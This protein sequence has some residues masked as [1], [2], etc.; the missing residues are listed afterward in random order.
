MAVRFGSEDAAV[1][2]RNRPSAYVVISDGSGNLV[3]VRSSGGHFLP[4]GG[5]SAGENEEEAVHREVLEE[6]GRHVNI[7]G[8]LG[9]ATELFEAHGTHYR[10]Q[11]VFFAGSF[12]SAVVS[13]PAHEVL[14]LPGSEAAGLVRHRSHAWAIGE[15][16]GLRCPPAN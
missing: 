5:I 10:M 9:E 4:G 2:Y 12:A 8:V 14:W 13:A 3:L 11:A 16:L 7:D 1:A 15:W 6:C